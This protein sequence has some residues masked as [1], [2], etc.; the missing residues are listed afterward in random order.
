MVDVVRRHFNA[1]GV[2]ETLDTIWW[3]RSRHRCNSG[4]EV[5]FFPSLSFFFFSLGRFACMQQAV[6]VGSQVARGVRQITDYP[7]RCSVEGWD[8]V[9][10]AWP[11]S[12]VWEQSSET[13]SCQRPLTPTHPCYS[14]QLSR[15]L[16]LNQQWISITDCTAHRSRHFL[17]VFPPCTGRM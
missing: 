1:N 17:S 15:I 10:V 2:K 3:D 5:L 11:I 7:S 14:F 16:S 4:S 13:R 9:S 12:P 8:N 6:P